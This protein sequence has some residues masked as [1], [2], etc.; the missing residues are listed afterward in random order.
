M[1]YLI[2]DINNINEFSM[3]LLSRR[4]SSFQSHVS[5]LDS[6]DIKFFVSLRYDEF[7]DQ[8]K[9]ITGFA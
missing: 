1:K 9:K 5:I 7:K 2:I 3:R 8:I 4:C 6:E